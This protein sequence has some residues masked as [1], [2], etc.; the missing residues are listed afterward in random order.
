ML[1]RM[2][3]RVL[4]FGVLKDLLGRESATLEG[5]V[6][7]LPADSTA[8][9]LIE[10]LRARKPNPNDVWNSL[11]VAV[12]RHYA[13][14]KDKLHDGD[15]VALLPPVSGGICSVVNAQSI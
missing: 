10:L 7:E 15:E 6:L 11:A 12:N 14:P 8:A 4:Y 5:E 3:I 13:N 9:E 1:V 2:K